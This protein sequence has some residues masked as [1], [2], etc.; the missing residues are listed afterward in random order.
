MFDD[1]T[2]G[3]A[4]GVNSNSTSSP[5]CKGTVVASDKRDSLISNLVARSVS[6][7]GFLMVE[8]LDKTVAGMW[9]LSTTGTGIQFFLLLRSVISTDA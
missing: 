8:R 3:S 6:S 4:T 9:C 7:V 5:T 2:G 1:R